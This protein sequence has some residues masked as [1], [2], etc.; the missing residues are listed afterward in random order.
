MNEMHIFF[1]SVRM[2]V[3]V[4][5]IHKYK[6]KES[7]RQYNSMKNTEKTDSFTGFSLIHEILFKTEFEKTTINISSIVY[8][9]QI[10]TMFYTNSSSEVKT[11]KNGMKNK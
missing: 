4:C 2:I 6:Q 9:R 5:M 1:S 3:F 7:L 11:L 10:K 8:G